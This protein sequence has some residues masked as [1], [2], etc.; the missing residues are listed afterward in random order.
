MQN[1]EHMN[2]RRMAS[3]LRNVTSELESHIDRKL[4]ESSKKE[5]GLMQRDFKLI[6]GL[7][8]VIFIL[9]AIVTGLIITILN[10][11]DVNKEMLVDVHGKTVGTAF[12]PKMESLGEYLCHEEGPQRA[13]SHD[14]IQM[15]VD[16][17]NMSNGKPSVVVI[18]PSAFDFSFTGA[19]ESDTIAIVT[20][21]GQSGETVIITCAS[22]TITLSGA[23]GQA[24][25]YTFNWTSGGGRRLLSLGEFLCYAFGP[26]YSDIRLKTD[27]TRT[28]TSPSGIPTYTYR[29]LPGDTF[30]PGLFTGTMAQDLL[31]MGYKDAV[32][33]M[34]NGF[35]AVN[36]DAIDVDFTLIEE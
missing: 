19:G 29:Y 7:G 34:P 15:L 36:Y 11:T 17:A 1:N 21:K 16:A 3:S 2:E 8:A 13:A 12:A 10:D 31:A 14:S 32:A 22:T 9:L 27:I 18:R 28:G 33:T 23:T 30:R 20:I 26:C 4:D 5:M 6:A 25:T 35:Y 24:S